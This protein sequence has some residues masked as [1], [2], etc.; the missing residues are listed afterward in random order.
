MQYILPLWRLQYALFIE[1]RLEVVV[2]IEILPVI[3]LLLLLLY[4]SSSSSSSAEII[5]IVVMDLCAYLLLPTPIS[6]YLPNQS[7]QGATHLEPR[8]VGVLGLSSINSS[9]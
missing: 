2:F 8:S 1:T 5:I 7:R 4:C 9:A 6:L 3:L